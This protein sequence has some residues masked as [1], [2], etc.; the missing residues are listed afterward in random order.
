MHTIVTGGAGFIGSHVVE[1][2]LKFGH[3]ITI[4]DDL[5]S[6]VR[7]NIPNH[8]GITFIEK[9]L[10]FLAPTEWPRNADSVIHLAAFPSVTDSWIQLR[11]AHENNLSGTVHALDKP[12]SNPKK[13]GIAVERG[14][15]LSNPNRVVAIS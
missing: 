13:F 9:T 11:R 7:R 12:A 1:L 3:Q 4:F 6:G 15:L 8:T 5:S 2:L 10:L 14:L